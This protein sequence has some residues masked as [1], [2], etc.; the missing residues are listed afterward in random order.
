MAD[1][2]EV[3]KKKENKIVTKIKNSMSAEKRASM[4]EDI[5]ATRYNLKKGLLFATDK[6]AGKVAVAG[7]MAQEPITAA[8]GAFI[9]K[10]GTELKQTIMEEVDIRYLDKVIREACKKRERDV[11]YY[12]LAENE[13]TYADAMWRKEQWEKEGLEPLRKRF[14]I[15]PEID[16]TV[17]VLLER[18]AQEELAKNGQ[19]MEKFHMKVK[20]TPLRQNKEADKALVKDGEMKR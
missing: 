19:K 7:A 14:N 6:V 10:H 2:M 5:D 17:S 12:K 20:R 3:I 4:K 16:H 8:T 9:K 13:R 1:S 11:E 18:Q 15:D